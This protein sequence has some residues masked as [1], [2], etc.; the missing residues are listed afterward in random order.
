MFTINS[1]FPTSVVMGNI[2]RELTKEELAVVDYHKTRTYN[3]VGNI[4]SLDRYILKTQLPEIKTFIEL[5]IKSYVDSILIPKHPLNFYITQ[6]WINYTD[7]GHHH[8]K[9]EHPNSIISGV[10][11]FNADSEKD[12][13]FFYTQ[14]YKQISITPKEWNIHN[15]DSWWFSV[16]TGGLILFPS[17]L[18]H[19]VENTTSDKTRISLAFNV[20]AKG[21]VGDEDRLIELH[22]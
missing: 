20:F 8:H 14:N 13:I 2:E 17:H 9:H 22:L 3:N 10:F 15:S 18:T 19:M 4:T 21:T 16:K 7:P 6:S 12:K 11:Y 1:I 5:G